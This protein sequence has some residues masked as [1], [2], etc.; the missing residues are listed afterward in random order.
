[1]ESQASGGWWAKPIPRAGERLRIG[2]VAD[3]H[4]GPPCVIPERKS[5][6]ALD[7]LKKVVRRFS[8]EIEPDV[9]VVLGDLVD[10]LPED[11]P[12][13]ELRKVR[14][15]L[16]TLRCPYVCIPGNHDGPP[17]P[18]Q[19]LFGPFPRRVDVAGASL[20]AF[21][22]R[23]GEG[24]V[25]TRPVEDIAWT[26]DHSQPLLPLRIA[27]QHNP[28]YPDIDSEY[29]Y[30]LQNRDEV[31]ESYEKVGIHLSLSG[32]FHAGAAPMKE[33]NVWYATVPALCEEPFRLV[34]I[35]V[36]SREIVWRM[37][38]IG[39]EILDI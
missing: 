12:P 1:M 20:L 26:I 13:V 37:E 27:V 6:L 29:P 7:L 10:F 32:H 39:R 24:D 34:V 16:E 33:G 17:E 22:D 38:E 36:D 4:Y 8:E 25:A 5:E 28:L 18:F 31:M 2:A 35:D 11:E 15:I 23:Y 21:A 19:R 3:L 30:V 14:E 9:V